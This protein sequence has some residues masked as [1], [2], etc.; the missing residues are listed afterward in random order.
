MAEANEKKMLLN[1][2]WNR[3]FVKLEANKSNGQ[4]VLL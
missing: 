4:R 3:I 1:L 2:D